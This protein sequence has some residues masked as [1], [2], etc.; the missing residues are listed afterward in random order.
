MGPQVLHHGTPSRAARN[1]KSCTWNP[2]S[3]A[4][5]SSQTSPKSCARIPFREPWGTV[6]P[7]SLL[8][9][10]PLAAYALLFLLADPAAGRRAAAIHAAVMWGAAV[11]AITEILSLFHAIAAPELAAAWLLMDLAATGYLER[12][13]R[14]AAP[15]G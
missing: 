1:P 9:G 3:C 5:S 12:P 13:Q 7:M 4:W 8:I 11:A 14:G 2:K 10:L 15:P 6:P